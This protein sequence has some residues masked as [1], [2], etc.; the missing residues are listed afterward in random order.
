MAGMEL[1]VGN[2]YRLGRKI[3]SGSFGDIYLGTNIQ[4]GEEVGIKLESIKTKHPQLLYESKLYKILQ[5]GTGIPNVR[6][7]GVEG[8]YNIMVLDLLGPSLEDL[9]N[10]CNRKFSLK[11]V[12]MLADQL[13]RDDPLPPRRP[14]LRAAHA[15]RVDPR[16]LGIVLGF[17]ATAGPCDRAMGRLVLEPVPWPGNERRLPVGPQISLAD[18]HPRAGFGDALRANADRPRRRYRESSTCTRRASFTATSS[19]ITSLWGWG[20]GRTR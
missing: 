9:F 12:L 1:R 18:V 10:F 8:D 20:S 11:T 2:K 7:F 5:G 19:R 3:G 6:W 16:V 15:G 17:R 13:V 4:T 14:Q